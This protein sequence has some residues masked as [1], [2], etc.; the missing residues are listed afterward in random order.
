MQVS[1]T[2]NG[3][4]RALTV[5]PGMTLLDALRDELGFTG[6]KRS[7][8]PGEC[9]WEIVRLNVSKTERLDSRL[10]K[11]RRPRATRDCC[12]RLTLQIA[13]VD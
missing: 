7:C 9:V 4:V 1:I 10:N 12:W 3:S 8:D 13:S 5:E 6:P 2:V 11:N